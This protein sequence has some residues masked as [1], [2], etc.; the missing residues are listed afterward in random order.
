MFENIAKTT[1]SKK[2][3]MTSINI[4]KYSW[5]KQTNKNTNK[6]PT[7]ICQNFFLLQNASQQ[8]F[9]SQV[10]TYPS[11]EKTITILCNLLKDITHIIL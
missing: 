4:Y 2:S 1:K 9:L 3:W 6:P 8:T 7:A 10:Y 5:Q 11:Y